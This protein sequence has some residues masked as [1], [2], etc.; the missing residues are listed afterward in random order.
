MLQAATGDIV[1]TGDRLSEAHARCAQGR[2]T[3]LQD[4]QTTVALAE[5]KFAEGDYLG[6]KH[7]LAQAISRNKAKAA[8]APRSVAAL[9]EA[10]STVALHEGDQFTYRTALANQV[11][12]LR[13]NLPADDMSV[14]AAST[15]YGDMWITLK[16]Y[17]NA[18][19][20][21]RSA[22][23]E[24]L[25]SGVE[26]A[27]L[28][29][30]IK[31]AWFYASVNKTADALRKLD[32][33]AARPGARAPDVRTTIEIL[34]LRI[35]AKDAD[36][37]KMDEL[38]KRVSASDQEQP[39]LL[40]AP[41]YERNALVEGN[42]EAVRL[43]FRQIIPSHSADYSK[44]QW[45][46]VGFW[47]RPDGRTEDADVLRS[48]PSVD[49]TGAVLQQIAG[50][51]YAADSSS[52]NKGFGQGRYRVE[53]FTRKSA[54]ETPIGSLVRRRVAS[55]GYEVIDLTASA[56]ASKPLQ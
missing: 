41:P 6:S 11:R 36:D 54:Y 56:R 8:E 30:G 21:Y 17:R 27:I 44:V 4:A 43:G 18:D 37:A 13:D 12:T 45:A 39:V 15:A 53:R 22:E 55:G 14:V 5:Q 48:S 26:P 10:Y 19:L 40:W 50:R 1:I 3:P 24:A 32:E 34:R 49:W 23:Q 2:C 35:A 31:R 33:V 51:R 46:D 25:R 28:R 20:A 7:V 52:R 16:K 29:T 47:I 9:Y 42:D 38:I